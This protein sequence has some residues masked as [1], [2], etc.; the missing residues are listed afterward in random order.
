M[1]IGCIL[2]VGC[3][4]YLIPRI[5]QCFEPGIEIR[6]ETIQIDGLPREYRLVIPDALTLA[7]AS[8]QF[9]LVFALHGAIDTTDEMAEYTGLDK[10]SAEQNFVLVYLQGRLLN[11]P[12]F[13]PPENPTVMEPD[14]R[15]FRRMCK[16]MTAQHPVDSTRIY[17]VG[18]SQGGAMTNVITANCSDLIAAAACNCG[19]L[20]EPLGATPLPTDNKCPM[21]FISGTRDRQVPESS[22]REGYNAFQAADHPVFFH[23]LEGAG[24]GWNR[25]SGVNTLVWQFLSRYRLDKDTANIP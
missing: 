1:T 17:V 25:K 12:P 6:H 13:I 8:M 3:I 10:L 2:L 18:V 23:R 11:W 22:V 14:L 20:P 7:D 21:L 9:P 4:A 15:F 5:L 19:W 16:K 24:H